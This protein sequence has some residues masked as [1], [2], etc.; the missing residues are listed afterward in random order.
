VV[1]DPAQPVKFVLMETATDVTRMRLVGGSLALD[2]VNT[3]SGPVSGPP[4]DDVLAGYGDLVGWAR[5]AG[6]LTGAEAARLHRR[7]RAD[8]DH[9]EA[10]FQ[11]A[12]RTRDYLDELFRTIAAGGRPAGRALVALR[13]DEVDALGRAAL[14]GEDPFE[15]SWRRDRTL[16]RPLH[17]VVHAAVELLTTGRLDRVKGCAGCRFLFV[18]ESKN[19]SRRWCS[20]DDCGT[21]AKIRRYVARRAHTRT[22]A[23]PP[24]PDPAR[25]QDG[26]F[27]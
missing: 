14:V 12:A 4:D 16:S 13:D 6:A 22:L 7:A 11:R 25:G 23:T 3:R 26:L 18:D 15:W 19:R 5:Y 21:T 27:S 20:M 1:P 17:P 10:T 2:F 24:Q 8:P 9:A